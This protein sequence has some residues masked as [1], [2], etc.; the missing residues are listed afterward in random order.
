[1]DKQVKTDTLVFVE[2]SDAPG[3]WPKI[4]PY[5]QAA[6]N[7]GGGKF[8]TF[9]WLAKILRGEADLFVS[10]DLESAAICEPVQFPL[11][12]V[13]CIVLIGGEGGHDW[14]AYQKVF[15]MAAK[16]R[17]CEI[18]ETFGRGGWRPVM[19]KLGYEL[20]HFVWRKEVT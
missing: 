11:T 1:M 12:R 19:K 4:E 7:H 3:V 5:V 17:G 8:A 16:V 13:Y 15:E 2:P 10:P 6:N 18:I 14:G 20:A 9:M